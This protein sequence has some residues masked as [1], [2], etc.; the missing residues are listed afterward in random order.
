MIQLLMIGEEVQK[1]QHTSEVLMRLSMFALKSSH[2]S[3]FAPTIHNGWLT[4]FCFRYAPA[5]EPY[6]PAL[7]PPTTIHM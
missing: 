4:K 5:A 2:D 7:M 6:A 1:A 3:A